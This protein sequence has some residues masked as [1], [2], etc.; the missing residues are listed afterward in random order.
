ML[1]IMLLCEYNR[2]S[3][4]PERAENAEQVVL[5]SQFSATYLSR[6]MGP[7]TDTE[8]KSV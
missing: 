5:G 7:M 3:V 2:L 6:F 4:W 8:Y 1:E